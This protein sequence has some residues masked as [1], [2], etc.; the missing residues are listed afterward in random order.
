MAKLNWAAIGAGAVR[1]G[2]KAAKE[3]GSGKDI[4]IGAVRGAGVPSF[5]GR[6]EQVVGGLY[7]KAA[8]AIAAGA[9]EV[10]GRG[11][12]FLHGRSSSAPAALPAAPDND[13]FS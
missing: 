8:P 10:I 7:D 3:G 4:T 5:G 9:K 1:G 2:V 12:N 6:T 13:P 11:A